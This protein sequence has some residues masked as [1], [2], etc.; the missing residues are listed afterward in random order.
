MTA[1]NQLLRTAREA[2]GKKAHE[3]AALVQCDTGR[4]YKLENGTLPV[5]EETI[6][7]YLAADLI[8]RAEATEA[9]LG[10]DEDAA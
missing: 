3:V 8:S 1:R 2:S 7:R 9:L 5:T 4:L 6:R 10:P